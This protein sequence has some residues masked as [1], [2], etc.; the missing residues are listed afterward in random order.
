MISIIIVNYNLTKEVDECLQSIINIHSS[1]EHEVIVVDNASPDNNFNSLTEKYSVAEFPHIHFYTADQNRGF[2]AGNNYGAKQATGDILFFLNPDTVLLEDIFPYFQSVFPGDLSI[3]AAG[4]MIVN[5][6]QKQEKSVGWFH[7]ASREL[8][9]VFHFRERFE[10]KQM[11]R[12][13]MVSGKEYSQV[14]WVTGS[15]LF[16][17]SSVFWEVGGFDE[18]FF[19]YNEEVDLCKR[20]AGLGYKTVYAPVGKVCHLGSIASK[21][22]YYSFTM[23][24]YESRLQY[25][26]KHF[27]PVN[28]FLIKSIVLIQIIVQIAFWSLT[29]LCNPQKA[30]EK[31]RA[32]KQIIRKYLA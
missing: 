26:L 27:T 7:S 11:S 1:V 3:A 9:D 14:D 4:P 29:Y 30:R 18:N 2:G 28:A 17:R 31:L 16:M 5:H 32:F 24:S 22:S 6:Q 12:L 10:R 23:S 19:L 21:K 20:V 13:P 15:A 8:L 25:I